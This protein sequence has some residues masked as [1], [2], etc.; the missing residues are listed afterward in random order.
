[1]PTPLCI[2]CDYDLQGLPESAL[3]PE[4]ATPVARS[5]ADRRLRNANFN[6]LTCTTHAITWL[7]RCIAFPV[8]AFTGSAVLSCGVALIAL[9]VTYTS[10]PE[11]A[12][13]LVSTIVLVALVGLSVLFFVVAYIPFSFLA[14]TT[15]PHFAS[16]IESLR[17]PVRMTCWAPVML[18]LCTALKTHIFR[19]SITLPAWAPDLFL[20]IVI[21][22]FAVHDAFL[23]RALSTLAAR[24]DDFNPRRRKRHRDPT[25]H[26]IIVGAILLIVLWFPYALAFSSRTP[27]IA[28]SIAGRGIFMLSALLA[29]ASLHF[30]LKD[31]ARALTE[32]LR[33]AQVYAAR[34]RD[35]QSTSGEPASKVHAFI[36][37]RREAR[38]RASTPDNPPPTS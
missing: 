19:V 29:I 36:Q 16:P 11:S 8:F 30:P 35:R 23:R 34:H 12:L 32:E 38:A 1:M 37:H 15:T 20:S 3:C 21:L 2:T 22:F 24:T 4:C 7:E 9:L 17:L 18:V 31:V 13:M 27:F 25:R 6:W 14:T 26:A 10:P 33:V 5:T 28:I